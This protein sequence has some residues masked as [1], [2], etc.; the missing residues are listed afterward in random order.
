M[1]R[2]TQNA[3]WQ[4]LKTTKW[5]FWVQKSANHK[6]SCLE[7]QNYFAGKRV[8]MNSKYEFRCFMAL[9][10]KKN[11]YILY[12]SHLCP[13][14]SG[15]HDTICVLIFTLFLF[16]MWFGKSRVVGLRW[17]WNFSP[18]PANLFMGWREWSHI[19]R[20]SYTFRR[21]KVLFQVY[22]WSCINLWQQ[23]RFG[24]FEW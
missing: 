20:A 19:Y 6:N 9:A 12:V 13:S 21:Y 10:G 22:R 8:H 17:G 24:L 15:R 23:C 7:P 5:P 1:N 18:L 2:F 3:V 16:L 14:C 4:N 11:V